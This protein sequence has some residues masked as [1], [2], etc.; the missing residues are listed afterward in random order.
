M[1]VV[2]HIC[3]DIAVMYLGKIIERASRRAFFTRPLHPYSVA[4]MSAVPT[5]R[6]GREVAAPRA[7][8]GR[9]AQPGGSAAGLPVRGRCPAAQPLCSAS[10]PPLREVAPGHDV[11]CHFV[12]RRDGALVAPL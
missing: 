11:A 1:A 5:V 8:D 7:A 12:E 2:E 3:D 10:E 6:G 9:S 4:L